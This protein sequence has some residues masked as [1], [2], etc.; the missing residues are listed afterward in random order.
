MI[1]QYLNIVE[2]ANKWVKGTK[3]MKGPK[4]EDAYR[5][6]VNYRR[7]LKRK[8]YALEDNPAAALYGESQVGKSYLASSLLSKPGSP[9]EVVDGKGNS[10]DFINQIN[11]EGKGIES[12]SLITRF[13]TDYELV[14]E[15]FPIKAKLLSIADLIL[16]L[17]DSYYNDVKAKMDTALKSGEIKEKVNEICKECQEV[18]FEQDLLTED[19]VLDIQD[20]F[21]R[22]FSTKASNVIHSDFFNKISK[23]IA[24]IKIE[25]WSEL[26]G[27]IWNNNQFIVDLFL[28]LLRSYEKLDYKT[29]VYL[30]IEAVLR[31]RG[32]LLDVKRLYDIYEIKDQTEFHFEPNV[33]VLCDL[34][35]NKIVEDF[36]K[37]YLCALIAELVF[38]L[39]DDWEKEKPFLKET[40]LL[41][42][43]GARHRLE[44][45]EEDL[46]EKV[47]P[48][49][50]LRGKVA[51]LFNKY[52]Y[53]QKI[54]IL[55][56]CQHGEDTKQGAVPELLNN[57]IGDMVGENPEQRE[58][59]LTKSKIP[60]LFV[61]S[62]KF[63]KD[64]EY[65]PRN[66]DKNNPHSLKTR[67]SRRFISALQKGVLSTETYDWFGNWTI[68]KP[69]FQNL[70]LLR[71]FYYSS[72]E[73]SKIFRGY[74]I[75]NKTEKEEI[76]PEGYPDLKEDLKQSF[77]ENPFVKSHFENPELAWD[78]AASINQDGSILI[79]ENLT[80]ASENINEA[81][82]D[83]IEKELS[84]IKDG[85]RLE[86]KKYYHDSDSDKRLIKAKK[87]A[88][89]IQFELDLAFGKDH[90]FF[91]PM[92]QEFMLDESEVFSLYQDKLKTIESHQ[93]VNSGKYS[94]IRLNVQNLDPNEDY[95]TNL[96]KLQKHYDHESIEE[97]E[98]YFENQ[99]IDLQE[100]FYGNSERVKQFSQVLAESLEEYWFERYLQNGSNIL[101]DA[102]SPVGL[103]N[104]QEMFK[105]LYKKLELTDKVAERIRT[106]VDGS[107]HSEESYGMI[108][109]LSAEIIN[110][111]INTVGIEY[112][113]ESDLS[114]LNKANTKNDLGLVLDHSELDFEE[115]TPEEAARLISNMDKLDQLLNQNPLPPDARRLPNYRSYIRWYHWLKVGFVSVCDIPNYDV[116]A[117]NKLEKIIESCEA[118]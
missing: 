21:K 71:D 102:F 94:G 105:T 48:Q 63:N 56:F 47:I 44:I 34:K 69:N 5:N 96:K 43:P 42:F 25:K 77:L 90:F 26:F 110:K 95:K 2:R 70:Y 17:C 81:R 82:R 62:T 49:M 92:I 112:Y 75:E 87:Q 114:D 73:R 13:S 99:G 28:N 116:E 106:Y 27:L 39:P 57:W 8:K 78:S 79:I 52:S 103:E 30:P 53:Y 83:K 22:H 66:D 113:T 46:E 29:E 59:F 84:E 91:G 4:G 107:T 37:S 15:D 72:E 36:S 85:I 104:T 16:V 3:A 88:G 50:L 12:T 76:I 74:D 10:Y 14:N 89:D 51:Y 18:D 45:H 64:L 54:N 109:D 24:R 32:T 115:N 97:C 23:N 80:V 41:D 111:F 11:P 38:R 86:L 19:E 108:A 61:I 118:V 55:L 67:W 9:F 93:V 65:D 33:S 7:Q 101:V 31:E 58:S 100:L 117:N 6:F 60:P 20:Y 40:D 35:K 1:E 68:S 98:E